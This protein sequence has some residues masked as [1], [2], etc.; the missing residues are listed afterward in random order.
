MKYEVLAPASEAFIL[1]LYGIGRSKISRHS[2][3]SRMRDLLLFITCGKCDNQMRGMQT[4]KG[5]IGDSADKP[6][7]LSRHRQSHVPTSKVEFNL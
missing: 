7:I 4:V 5:V 3:L 2:G 6:G 1:R